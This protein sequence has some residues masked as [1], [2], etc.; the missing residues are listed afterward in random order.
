MNVI[1]PYIQNNT[2]IS[3]TA[4]NVFREIIMVS[5]KQY[6]SLI[7]ALIMN[8]VHQIQRTGPYFP[9]ND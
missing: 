7:P 8:I 9:D 2:G 4:I 1:K 5:M 3:N 6:A